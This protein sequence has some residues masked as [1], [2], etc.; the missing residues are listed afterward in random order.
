MKYI[1]TT[2]CLLLIS[3]NLSAQQ[4]GFGV[5]GGLTVGT[6]KDKR[7][8]VSYHGAAFFETLSKWKEKNVTSRYGFVAQLGY[9]RRG[10][11]YNA[12]IWGAN[13]TIVAN[14]IFHNLS[15]ATLLKGSYKFGNLLPYYATGLRLDVTVASSVINS[16]D[17][18]G[19]TPVNF[20]LW[21]GGG[22][23]W[24]PVK[25]PF[26]LFLEVNISP[27]LTPQVFF[28]R[29]TVVGYQSWNSSTTQTRTFGEDYRIINV[30]IEVSL[31][32]KFIARKNTDPE[33]ADNL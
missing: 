23:D 3:F 22:I 13:N 10:G 30:C 32:V 16:I 26:G 20:G 25:L 21:L 24:E 33:E 11:S 5:K 8:L 14:D 28:P 2:I 9:H 6:Q 15:L 18:Q 17:A 1:L 27:D 19:I 12:G 31:G 4:M 29:G 7:A